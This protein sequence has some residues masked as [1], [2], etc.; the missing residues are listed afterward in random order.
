MRK[1]GLLALAVSAVMVA[2]VVASADARTET[3]F[4]VASRIDKDPCPRLDAQ[5]RGVLARHA[6]RASPPGR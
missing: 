4:S 3:Q 1:A 2:S 5:D 6:F